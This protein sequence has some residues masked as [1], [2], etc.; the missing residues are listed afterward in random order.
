MSVFFCLHIGMPTQSYPAEL[1]FSC[2]WKMTCSLTKTAYI[3]ICGVSIE[4]NI[5]RLF[6]RSSTHLCLI[7]DSSLT[8]LWLIFDSSSTYLRLIFDSSSTHLRLIFDSS[9]THLRL[10]FNSSSTHYSVDFILSRLD[11]YK[12]GCMYIVFIYVFLLVR[13]PQK[14]IIWRLFLGMLLG[15]FGMY[16]PTQNLCIKMRCIYLCRRHVQLCTTM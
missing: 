11:I 1:P 9:S 14:E 4:K 10:I 13:V 3:H 2:E 8:H 5:L 12:G 15:I 6:E 16:V 7:F